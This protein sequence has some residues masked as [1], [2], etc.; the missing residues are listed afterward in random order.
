MRLAERNKE[1][2]CSFQ[3]TQTGKRF[4][5]D[6][7]VWLHK[8]TSKRQRLDTDTEVE[9][10]DRGN[11]NNVCNN[12]PCKEGGENA[13]VKDCAE[14]FHHDLD[15][16]DNNEQDSSLIEIW[17]TEHPR[18][19]ID[20]NLLSLNS[21]DDRRKKS[22]SCLIRALLDSEDLQPHDANRFCTQSDPATRISFQNQMN[23]SQSHPVVDD[24]AAIGE[25]ERAVRYMSTYLHNWTRK[26]WNLESSRNDS[27]SPT[28]LE[29]DIDNVIEM[30][31]RTHLFGRLDHTQERIDNVP[32][33]KVETQAEEKN[34]SFAFRNDVILM[35]SSEGRSRT[36]CECRKRGSVSRENSFLSGQE[37]S[38][39][40]LLKIPPIVSSG[41]QQCS[42][43]SSCSMCTANRI[44]EPRS[45]Q[46]R[47]SMAT[48]LLLNEI[49]ETQGFDCSDFD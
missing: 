35:S 2:E 33:Q 21:N 38:S 9:Q 43:S 8:S 26:L 20:Q 36:R 12:F 5:K 42:E 34:D 7:R 25:E 11:G 46:P 24:P 44:H 4:K 17:N 28:Q 47:V 14:V 40:G 3:T 6:S 31:I 15:N 48:T 29:K 18:Y 1:E 19:N 39:F 22:D 37:S 10:Q 32:E 23:K 27:F 49:E 41:N 13:S 45:K 16:D 30:R